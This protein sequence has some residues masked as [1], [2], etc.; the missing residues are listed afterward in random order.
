MNRNEIV[1]HVRVALVQVLNRDVSE[2]GRTPGCSRTFP[3][4]PPASSSC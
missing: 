3:W 1:E 2:L 4:T